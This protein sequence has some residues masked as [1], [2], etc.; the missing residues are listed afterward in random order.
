MRLL[1]TGLLAGAALLSLASCNKPAPAAGGAGQ[2]ASAAPAAPAP[3]PISLGSLPRR[4]PGLWRQTLAMEGVSE[5][6]PATE[7]C[8]DA[9]SEAKMSLLSQ[10]MRRGQCAPP[11]LTRNLD[12]SI[13]FNTSCD[14]GPEGKVVSTGT[15]S[16]D[17]N[18]A[19]KMV[20]DS[21]H[22]GAPVAA[23]NGEHKMTMT[24]TWL[25]P[26]QPGEKGGDMIM[27]DGRK[28]NF[29]DAG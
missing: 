7:L 13:S 8:T 2:T 17:F 1:T 21:T 15:V 14:M 25:G 23:A 24:S 19:F 22:T 29:T 28:I 3:G 16:G 9:E 26:C 11:Q 4:K 12:G 5:A 18:S 6:M 20:I 10:Q 27:P